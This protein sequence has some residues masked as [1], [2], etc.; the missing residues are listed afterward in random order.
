M[1]APSLPFPRILVIGSDPAVRELCRESLPWAGCATE[2]A[3]DIADAMTSDFAADVVLAD[4]PAGAQAAAALL[5]LREFAAA[6]GS[7]VIALT[8]DPALLAGAPDLAGV[9]VLARSCS[10]ETLWDAL[11]IAT[12]DEDEPL[13]A[14]ECPPD[15]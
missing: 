15:P 2:F 4:L 3:A 9:Q 13:T 11:A 7:T 6:A 8:D 10:A 1:N 12:T 5:H 14:A